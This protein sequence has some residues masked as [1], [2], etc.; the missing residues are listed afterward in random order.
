MSLSGKPTAR[1]DTDS[2]FRERSRQDVA[3][4]A[5]GQGTEQLVERLVALCLKYNHLVVR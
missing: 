2:G 1:S 5:I 3:S 4:R